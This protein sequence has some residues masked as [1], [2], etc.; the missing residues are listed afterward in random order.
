VLQIV[1][2]QEPSAQEIAQGLPARRNELVEQARAETFGI[3]MQTLIDNYTK[4][5]AIRIVAAPKAAQSP[6]AGM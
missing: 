3:Y 1:D 4:K 6:L 5:G 2:K